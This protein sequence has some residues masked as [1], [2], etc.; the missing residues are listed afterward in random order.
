MSTNDIYSMKNE[1][2][3]GATGEERR[4]GHREVVDR[5]PHLNGPFL[6]SK[7]GKR[8]NTGI[9]HY[10]NAALISISDKAAP[11]LVSKKTASSLPSLLDPKH[12][13]DHPASPRRRPSE[14]PDA[15][16]T[17]QGAQKGDH[18]D[19]LAQ[20]KNPDPTYYNQKTTEGCGSLALLIEDDEPDY[21]E[22]EEEEE[23]SVRARGGS[24]GGVI[25]SG[26]PLPYQL[27]AVAGKVSSGGRGQHTVSVMSESYEDMSGMEDFIESYKSATS[28]T[29]L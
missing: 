21:D 13:N 28:T 7:V 3:G 5:L 25:G 17:L 6:S 10:K 12:Y 2:S 27:A 26:R 1:P 22:V 15:L 16:R 4:P 19:S 20:K 8:H 18:Y 14:A 24:A 11:T 23:E 29:P 9:S